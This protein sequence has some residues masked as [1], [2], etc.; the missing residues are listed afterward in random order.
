MNIYLVERIDE[1]NFEELVECVVSAPTKSSAKAMVIAANTSI[2]SDCLTV[3]KL[4]TA[5][6]GMDADLIV[7]SYQVTYDA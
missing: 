5:K 4:G 6:K 2:S 1:Y 7:Q 3:K